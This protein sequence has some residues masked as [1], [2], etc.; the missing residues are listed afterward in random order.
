AFSIDPGRKEK[1]LKGLDAVGETLQHAGDISVY[2][3][4]R[5]LA[6]PWQDAAR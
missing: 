6:Q 4:R 2:E 1:L 5:K 3:E